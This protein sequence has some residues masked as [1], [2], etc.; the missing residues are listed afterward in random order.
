MWAAIIALLAA[1]LTLLGTARIAAVQHQHE[2]KRG[3]NERLLAL[4]KDVFL[5]GADGVSLATTTI[6]RIAD[7]S[8]PD[9][10]LVLAASEVSAILARVQVIGNQE[11]IEAI[12][13]LA[14]SFTSAFLDLYLE[15]LMTR[16]K[17]AEIDGDDAE[18]MRAVAELQIPLAKKA[19]ERGFEIIPHVTA[20]LFAARE[21]LGISHGSPEV[22][23]DPGRRAGQASRNCKA[24]LGCDRRSKDRSQLNEDFSPSFPS[25]NI[26]I[27]DH[28]HPARFRG[29][30]LRRSWRFA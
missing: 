26:F 9:S 1:S 27:A 15:R 20:A 8:V 10:D 3:E 24:V 23:E 7:L 12:L 5:R 17:I 28:K 16:A 4:R 29:R 30:T 22:F 25:F 13:A 14:L 11:T 18:K 6:S 2:T 21:E 19:R